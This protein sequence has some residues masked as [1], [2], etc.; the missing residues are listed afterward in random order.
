MLGH[1]P[2]EYQRLR[3][4]ARSWSRATERLLDEVG[5]AP[6]AAAWTPGAA[7]AR[8]CAF[9]PTASA[10][11]DEVLGIDVDA[12][13]AWTTRFALHGEGTSSATSWST[14]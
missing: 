2:Q 7:R 10:P 13:L 8:R 14:T 1:S 12:A 6:G 5:L 3:A 4:Q 11:T 9:W